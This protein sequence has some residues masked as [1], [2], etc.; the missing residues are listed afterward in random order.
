MCIHKVA[1]AKDKYH[2]SITYV[3]TICSTNC[4]NQHIYFMRDVA[5]GNIFNSILLSTFN[6][7]INVLL[8]II[9]SVLLPSHFHGYCIDLHNNI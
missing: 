4:I 3:F 2:I 8:L 5:I 1:K 6:S 9:F 7:C